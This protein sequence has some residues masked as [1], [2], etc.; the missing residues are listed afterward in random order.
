MQRTATSF[1]RPFLTSHLLLCTLATFTPPVFAQS[2]FDGFLRE[3]K[4][5]IK[6]QH[7]QR[8]QSGSPPAPLNAQEVFGLP[9]AQ[10]PAH[11]GP[12]I[13][14]DK[15]EFLEATRSGAL[16][17]AASMSSRDRGPLKKSIIQILYTDYRVPYIPE[18]RCA[19]LEDE[20][21]L[22]ISMIAA[23]HMETL[24]DQAPDFYKPPRQ[25]DPATSP[26]TLQLR[27]IQT[28]LWDGCDQK[29]LGKL[30][31]HPYRNALI[32]LL[33][34]Y[35]EATAQYV[36]ATRDQRVHAYQQQ[37]AE[38]HQQQQARQASE[39]QRIAQEAERI[40]E[41][42]ERRVRIQRNRVGG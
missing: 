12:V 36:A 42:E 14:R 7:Q 38:R 4:N 37:Q 22:P 34:E 18:D 15:V 2:P 41:E 24:S 5:S 16:S 29:V 9:H 35:S 26:L 19:G 30:T 32:Q 17:N 20:V 33:K 21:Y 27:S 3:L 8:G 39:R 10:Q 40:R 13:W 28:N 11:G 25:Q 23:A 31:P 6:Q 1:I